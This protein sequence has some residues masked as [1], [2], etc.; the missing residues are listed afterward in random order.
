M[1][2]LPAQIAPAESSTRRKTMIESSDD[3]DE[4]EDE[5]EGIVVRV[6]SPSKLVFRDDL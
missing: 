4:D 1:S 5:D 3:D 2:Q 6:D